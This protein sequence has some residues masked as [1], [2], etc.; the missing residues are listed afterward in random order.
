MWAGWQWRRPFASLCGRATDARW[1]R[2]AMRACLALAV[3]AGL[4]VC[5]RANVRA[6]G[7][8]MRRLLEHAS[9]LQGQ[10][11][12][13]LYGSEQPLV[14]EKTIEEAKRMHMGA[15][16]EGVHASSQ[17]AKHPMANRKPGLMVHHGMMLEGE[18][19]RWLCV[20]MAHTCDC[21]FVYIHV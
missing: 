4:L 16:L 14:T 2:A 5:C 11:T 13:E 6:E 21:V 19:P 8:Q 10:Q 15:P 18:Q 3:L 20:E 17:P 9:K 7:E 1:R 12:E